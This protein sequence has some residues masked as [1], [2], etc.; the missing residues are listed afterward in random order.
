VRNRRS[1]LRIEAYSRGP[2]WNVRL[3]APSDRL[4]GA[5]C[6]F[7]GRAGDLGE[8]DGQLSRANGNLGDASKDLPTE[9]RSLIT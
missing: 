3:G 9:D 2:N 4:N 1:E 6:K 8:A 5:N 7:C